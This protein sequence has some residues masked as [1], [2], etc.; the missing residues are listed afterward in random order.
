LNIVYFDIL[1]HDNH[2]NM[3][4]SIE[5]Q[6][7]DGKTHRK[8]YPND[9]KN[10]DLMFRKIKEILKIGE[11]NLLRFRLCYNEITEIKSFEQ[12]TDLQEFDLS[13]NLI[14]QIKGLDRMTNIR[15]LD[16]HNNKITRIKGLEQLTNLQELNLSFNQITR[17]EGLDQLTNLRKLNLHSN[18]IDRIEGLE[19][20]TNLREL[21]L[22]RNQITRIEGLERLTNLRELLLGTNQITRIEGFEQLTNLR[23]FYLV[24]NRI[25]VVPMSIMLL[26]NLTRFYID[27]AIDPIIIRFMERNVIRT[28]RTIFDD[29][30]NVHDRTINRQIT[31]SL[32]RLMD[33]K[34]EIS[35]ECVIDQII[36]DPILS[37]SVKEAITEY[38][39]IP[40]VHS[41][42]N[43]TFMEALR[44]VWQI[45]RSHKYSVEIKKIFDQEMQDSIC[46]CFTGRLARLVNCLN[47]FDP[48]VCIKISE[49]QEISNIIVAIRQKYN[50]VDDQIVAVKQEMTARGYSDV[51]IDL[52]IGYLE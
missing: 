3:M 18:L 17:I 21:Y 20:V 28:N 4:R 19:R 23:E 37:R 14:T 41:S 50:K 15:N 40:D 5:Y 10:I 52:W 45:I 31:Q 16:L 38:I 51:T 47:G 46:R 36:N 29:P 30:Q 35:E 25:E 2:N 43:V 11:F 27:I 34:L 9:I 1:D 49:S 48:R 7:A 42:L 13:Y 22:S 6:T 33:C 39:K 12:L 24:G 44:V 8:D 32:F 26:R